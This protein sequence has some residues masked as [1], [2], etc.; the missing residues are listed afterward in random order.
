MIFNISPVPASRPRV[1]R[2]STYFP[3]KYTQFRKDF[4]LILDD[5]DIELSE[6]LLYAKLDFFMQIPKSW[7]NKKKA[8]KEGKYADNNV[9]V[10]NLVKACLDSCEG[11]FY[12]NDNQVAMIRARKFY[13]IDGRIEM[14]LSSI[15]DAA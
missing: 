7:S 10:D 9:D 8:D 13:S 5:L 11:V 12:E 15:K 1:T 4:K 14:E 6:G 2:W 3:K